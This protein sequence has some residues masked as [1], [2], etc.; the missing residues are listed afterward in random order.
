MTGRRMSIIPTRG[1]VG[2]KE[3]WEVDGW[4]LVHS[5]GCGQWCTRETNRSRAGIECR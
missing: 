1:C 3:F 4:E 5:D 2:R